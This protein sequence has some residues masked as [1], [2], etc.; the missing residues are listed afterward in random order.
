MWVCKKDGP[1]QW[2]RTACCAA[3]VMVA[4]GAGMD[5][6]A[7]E[8]VQPPTDEARARRMQDLQKEAA[9][10]RQE[11]E[12]LRQGPE[13]VTQSTAPRSELTEQPTRHMRESLES[14]PG[15]TVRQGEGPR[16]F[17]I[18]IRGSGK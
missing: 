17:N 5:A 13:G 12:A 18:S 15:M 10:I 7:Q 16:D 4:L 3:L 11:L 6:A 2:A 1:Y 8:R 14:L 9:R